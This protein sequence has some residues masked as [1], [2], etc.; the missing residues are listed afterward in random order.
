[1][2]GSNYKLH[3]DGIF[4]EC[5]HEYFTGDIYENEHTMTSDSAY[6]FETS[7]LKLRGAV[8]LVSNNDA[9]IGNSSNQRYPKSAGTSLSVGHIDLSKL[10]FKNAT[11]G[12]NTKINII[13]AKI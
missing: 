7:E 9:L 13:G 1:M 2:S 12:Q 10:Y 11:S 8:I 5:S 3:S 6:R 4:A